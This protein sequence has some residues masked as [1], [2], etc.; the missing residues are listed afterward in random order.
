[1]DLNRIF[2]LGVSPVMAMLFYFMCPLNVNAAMTIAGNEK[3]A[4]AEVGSGA[5]FGHTFH[6][7]PLDVTP[8]VGVAGGYRDNIF[9]AENVR[10]GS[11]FYEVSP[12]VAVNVEREKSKYAL[13]YRAD[14]GSFTSSSQDDYLDH[15]VESRASFVLSE[16]L[17]TGL[18][19]NYSRSHDERG[20]T[21]T[22]LGFSGNV[23]DKYREFDL[24]MTVGY[25]NNNR[26]EVWGE[27]I[28]KRYYNN[29]YKVFSPTQVLPQTVTRD[30]DKAGAGIGFSWQIMPKTAVVIEVRYTRFDYKFLSASVNLDSNEQ[31]YFTGINW[32]ATAKT[33]GRFRVGYLVKRFT[34]KRNSDFSGLGTELGVTWSPKTYSI[35][36]LSVAYEPDETD[37]TGSFIRSAGGALAWNH[38]WS[39]RF[40]H[41]ASLGYSNQRFTGLGTSRRDNVYRA[42]AGVAYELFNWLNLGLSY[43]Y[44]YRKS[45]VANASYHG[46]KYGVNFLGTM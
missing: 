43:G 41:Q 13:L 6:I 8:A 35:F 33:S 45:N 22:G 26:V 28:N 46:N 10:K 25:G 37:G 34:D 39:S 40:S 23:P 17:D 32:D 38:E 21:F 27:Y 14:I 3:G 24:G 12:E 11:V 30:L 44:Q 7:G 2:R 36:D 15:I 16:K 31:R 1:M 4:A 19:A 42:G 29:R 9:A 5:K 20:S 18:Y